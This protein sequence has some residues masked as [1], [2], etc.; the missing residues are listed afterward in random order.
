MT[1][2][3]FMDYTDR[4]LRYLNEHERASSE[5]RSPFFYRSH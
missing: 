4:S 2:A 5:A 3:A 1:V